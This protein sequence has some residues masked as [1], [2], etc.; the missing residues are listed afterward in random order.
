VLDADF[1][2]FFGFDLG[3]GV[4]EGF[5]CCGAVLGMVG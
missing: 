2:G 5:G 1:F 3:G 4:H